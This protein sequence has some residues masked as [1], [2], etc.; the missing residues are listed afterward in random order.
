MFHL[1]AGHFSVVGNGHGSC[2]PDVKIGEA[3]CQNKRNYTCVCKMLFII[4]KEKEPNPGICLATAENL[5]L[6]LTSMAF[7]GT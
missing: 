2:I 5:Q 6:P 3:L 1:S 4:V 7:T